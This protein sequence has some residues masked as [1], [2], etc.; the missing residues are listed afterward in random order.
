[1]NRTSL[2]ALAVAATLPTLAQAADITLSFEGATSFASIADFYSDLGVSFSDAALAL[3]NDELGPYFS[4]APTPGTVMFA[5]DSSAV[6]N[7]AAGFVDR[8]QFFYSAANGGLDLV[9]IYSG[10]NGTGTLLASVSLF[11]N[12]AL[13]CSDAPFCRFDL[14]SV[15]FAGVAHS[16]SFGGDAGFV[17]YDNV[18][19]TAVPEPS[20]LA[21]LL[22]GTSALAFVVRRRS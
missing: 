2:I 4:H 5:S 12:A 15:K 10:L 20:P 11:G 13:A 3:S 16:V 21:L 7:V 22:A 17:A 1:M 14:T 9:N 18:S 19:I 6:M 8:L